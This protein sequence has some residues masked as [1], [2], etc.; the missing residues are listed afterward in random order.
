MRPA[1]LVVGVK[2]ANTNCEHSRLEQADD[3]TSEGN[4]DDEIH[5]SFMSWHETT[6]A[7]IKEPCYMF[8]LPGV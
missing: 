1:T 8:K 3:S 7:A 2:V 6:I 5:T 4:T